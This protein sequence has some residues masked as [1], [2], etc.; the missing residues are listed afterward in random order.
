[1]R[2]GHR[3]GFDR[4]LGGNGGPVRVVRPERRYSHRGAIAARALPAKRRT[5]CLPPRHAI[6]D[7]VQNHH[8]TGT[9]AAV[10]LTPLGEHPR[11]PILVDPAVLTNLGHHRTRHVRVVG[12]LP[13]PGRWT[14]GD[15]AVHRPAGHEKLRTERITD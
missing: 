9:V 8:S 11:Q 4:F 7:L 12:P 10:R 2:M 5:G 14:T 3:S 13:R 15:Q 1:M 6:A